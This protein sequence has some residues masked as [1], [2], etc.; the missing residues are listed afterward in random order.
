MTTAIQRIYDLGVD[1]DFQYDGQWFVWD[2]QKAEANLKKHGIAFE[3]ACSVFFDPIAVYE[4]AS[5]GF[6][7]REAAI[8][9][10]GGSGLLFVVHLMRTDDTIRIISARETT[11]KE[12]SHYEDHAG[13][14]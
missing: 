12:R 5:A 4:D 7:R 3:E 2:T 1:F 14:A 6:E 13:K 11:R 10:S 8:G 9:R